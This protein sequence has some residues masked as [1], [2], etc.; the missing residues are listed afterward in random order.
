MAGAA[1]VAVD[2]A[3]S[4]SAAAAQTTVSAVPGALP[5][6]QMPTNHGE[7]DAE[8]W[9]QI[10]WEDRVKW[11]QQWLLCIAQDWNT[12]FRTMNHPFAWDDFCKGFVCHFGVQEI[13]STDINSP[14]RDW[15]YIYNKIL[16]VLDDIL[17][18]EVNSVVQERG[19]VILQNVDDSLIPDDEEDVVEE[20]FAVLNNNLEE[21]DDEL[22]FDLIELACCFDY[23]VGITNGVVSDLKEGYDAS[24]SDGIRLNFFCIDPGELVSPSRFK[25]SIAW[26]KCWQCVDKSEFEKWLFLIDFGGVE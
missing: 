15:N 9:L 16:K 23:S 20:D 13:D 1:G 6:F 25:S 26:D 3:V 19:K 4:A 8:E 5:K 11:V 22:S 24:F 17:E 10:P 14:E 12:S 7:D 2:L 21:S 18:L